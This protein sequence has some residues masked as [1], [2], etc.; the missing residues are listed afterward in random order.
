MNGQTSISVPSFCLIMY[1]SGHF[2]CIMK[3]SP[4]AISHPPVCI[5]EQLWNLTRRCG[6]RSAIRAIC[7]RRT[8]NSPSC[9]APISTSI[10][11][12]G[13]AQRWRLSGQGARPSSFWDAETDLSGLAPTLGHKEPLKQSSAHWHES[14]GGDLLFHTYEAYRWIHST[15]GSTAASIQRHGRRSRLYE[16]EAEGLKRQISSWALMQKMNHTVVSHI[17]F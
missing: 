7:P 1:H 16:C 10:W 11:P 6:C 3:Q 13:A 15:S 4:V 17:S 9:Q 12:F 5:K 2:T 8:E 14:S